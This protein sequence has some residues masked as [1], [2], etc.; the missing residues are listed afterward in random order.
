MDIDAAVTLTQ[1]RLA[2]E[3]ATMA[4][5]LGYFRNRVSPV[6]VGDAAWAR[7][8]ECAGQLPITMGALPFGFELP[9]HDHRPRAD[10]GVSLASGTRPAAFFEERERTDASDE[11]ARAIGRVFRQMDA[12]GSP[13]GE[14]VGRKL[15]LEY[16][17]GSANDG[18]RPLPGLF[19]RP[20]ER[21]I[22]GAS[23]QVGDVGT[24]VDALVLLRRLGEE[25]RR[26]GLRGAGLPRTAGRYAPRLVRRLPFPAAGDPTRDHGLQEPRQEVGRYLEDTGWPGEIPAVD[27]VIARF[28]ERAEIVRTGINVDV[29]EEGLGPTLGLTLIVKQRYTKDSRYWLD[30]LTD[31]DPFLEAL[32]QEELVVP[33]KLAELAHWVS[34]PTP[35]FGK[36]G[37][38]VLLR[39]IHH[40]KL[41]LAGGRLEKAKAYVF[42]VLSSGVLP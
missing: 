18:E 31:W 26:T 1:D 22:V 37:R 4:D 42:M 21:P 3:G 5:L 23:G 9:L 30:G 27:S 36:S 25:S 19:L 32:G 41:V 28:R 38:F 15:M 16:D 6:L 24:V 33:E 17:I 11:T 7:I 2:G 12:E 29:L 14:I 34:K 35:L 10:L 8:L 20:G 39:G 40:I 13:L